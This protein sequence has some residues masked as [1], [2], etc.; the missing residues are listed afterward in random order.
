[1]AARKPRGAGA[2]LAACFERGERAR[3]LGG[4]DLGALVGLDRGQDVSH[5]SAIGDR[6]QAIEAAFGLAGIDRFGGELDRLLEVLGAP[7]PRSG[8]RRH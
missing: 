1:M 8:R 6:D 3:A 4:R 5:L 2:A 7:P